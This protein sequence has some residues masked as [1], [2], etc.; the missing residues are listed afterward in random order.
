MFFLSSYDFIGAK[1]VCADLI[2]FLRGKMGLSC[3]PTISWGQNGFVVYY[4]EFMGVKWVFSDLKRF[5]GGK[6]G[7]L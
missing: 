2:R 5:H 7:I 1:W 3:T 6:M 4:D